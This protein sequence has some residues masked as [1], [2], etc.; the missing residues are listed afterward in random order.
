[1]KWTP[2]V[3]ESCAFEGDRCQMGMTWT[4]PRRRWTPKAF[5]RFGVGLDLPLPTPRRASA[6]SV[7][8]TRKSS[9]NAGHRPCR[10]PKK[11]YL[12]QAFSKHSHFLFTQN[13]SFR[14]HQGTEK[15]L[16]S[17]PFLCKCP[18][19]PAKQPNHC[20]IQAHSPS[21][22]PNW[23]HFKHK[24]CMFLRSRVSSLEYNSISFPESD[25]KASNP[26]AIAWMSQKK[27]VT[28]DG[29][30]PES[31]RTTQNTTVSACSCPCFL[32][33]LQQLHF[34]V[35]LFGLAESLLFRS[36]GGG[37][38]WN[39]PKF[40]LPSLQCW[41]QLLRPSLVSRESPQRGRR[42]HGS[43]ELPRWKRL[44]L[45]KSGNWG[46]SGA[47][48]WHVLGPCNHCLSVC[49]KGNGNNEKLGKLWHEL[50]I[51]SP[52][53]DIWLYLIAVLWHVMQSLVIKTF[54]LPS[55]NRISCIV[56]NRVVYPGNPLLSTKLS[57]GHG[58]MASQRAPAVHWASKPT[59]VNS[60]L[61]EGLGAL[62]RPWRFTR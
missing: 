58:P 1:M 30:H 36:P 54:W 39:F 44:S 59:P 21:N 62:E 9:E 26:G 20:F 46:D 53:N 24:T 17:D 28:L 48:N 7:S 51:F 34:S 31:A 52:G 55:T 38:P 18:W 56:A 16:L 45:Q 50:W 8:E 22:W 33:K 15:A 4:T 13:W 41:P 49:K 10:V 2:F 12:F 57:N 6:K 61:C 14:H 47:P 11:A 23:K 40:Q 3:E 35:V 32:Q 60:W 5:H 43:S 19:S 37:N 25:S 27:M 29:I 42:F